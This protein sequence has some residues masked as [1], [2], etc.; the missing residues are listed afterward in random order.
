LGLDPE[1]TA[2]AHVELALRLLEEGK[3]L[4]DR[5]PVRLVKS[6]TRLQRRLLRH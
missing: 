1:I 3:E 2:E 6:F 5:D 4:V